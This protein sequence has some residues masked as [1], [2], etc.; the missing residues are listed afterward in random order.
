MT[1]PGPAGRLV[2][3]DGLRVRVDHELTDEQVAYCLAVAI[4]CRHRVGR[5]VRPGRP[6]TVAAVHECLAA[7]VLLAGWP[8]GAGEDIQH[9][10][11]ILAQ[12][13]GLAPFDPLP[14]GAR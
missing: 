8:E 1:T 13:L 10:A 6:E 5:L 4:A 9:E 7:Q 3:G 14:A 11:V 12:R 2:V